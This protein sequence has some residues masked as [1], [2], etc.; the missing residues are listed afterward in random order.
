MK[1]YTKTGD[2]GQTGLFGGARVPKD[3]ARVEAYGS[4]DETNALLGVAASASQSDTIREA[5][6]RIQ[7]ELFSLGA[8]LA[9]LPEHR[10]KLQMPFIDGESIERLERRI[11]EFEAELSPLKNFILPGGTLAA[12]L[13][14]QARTVC[15]RAERRVRSVEKA[16][17]LRKELL[18]YLNRLGDLLFVMARFEN[19]AAGAS[20]H[21]WR[22]REPT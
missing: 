8:E 5:L 22:P 7:T 2:D 14:H 19:H 4:V 20:E 10:A 13:L 6:V 15:R 16:A 17:K 18:V 3:D 11:D 1:I 21:P 9:C 12:A